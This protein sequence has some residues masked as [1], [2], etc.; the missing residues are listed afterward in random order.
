[1]IASVVLNEDYQPNILI[2]NFSVWNADLESCV[3]L[4][5]SVLEISVWSLPYHF[6]VMM[7]VTF[8]LFIQAINANATIYLCSE[9]GSC[10]CYL[11]PQT[12]AGIPEIHPS[13][14]SSFTLQGVYTGAVYYVLTTES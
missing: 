6:Q 3:S 2:P 8:I 5:H 12:S 10:C 13:P 4:V 11:Y 7:H 9:N 14:S 1:M